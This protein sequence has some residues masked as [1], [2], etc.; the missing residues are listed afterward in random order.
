MIFSLNCKVTQSQ[1]PTENDTVLC[2]PLAHNVVAASRRRG[3]RQGSD[4][5]KGC[6]YLLCVRRVCTPACVKPLVIGSV[7]VFVVSYFSFYSSSIISKS[8]FGIKLYF[9]QI[10]NFLSSTSLIE[11]GKYE[12]D[13]IFI[14]LSAV[15]V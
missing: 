7:F 4:E 6:C 13:F 1:K 2:T 15:N 8:S 14:F 9:S 10:Y 3:Y 5:S 12:N 11:S